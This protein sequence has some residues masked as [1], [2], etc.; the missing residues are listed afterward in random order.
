MKTPEEI[1]IETWD[2]E[3]MDLQMCITLNPQV[4]F[5]KETMEKYAKHYYEEKVNEL[6][7]SDVIKSVCECIY[8]ARKMIGSKCDACGKR[9]WYR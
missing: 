9:V 8:G 1:L 5:I 6:N 3:N 7:K 2:A 4:S